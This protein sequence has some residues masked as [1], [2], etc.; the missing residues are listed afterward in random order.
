MSTKL[1]ML[2]I[3]LAFPAITFA[4]TAEAPKPLTAQEKADIY[5]L[6]A[7]IHECDAVMASVRDQFTAQ[8]NEAV[9]TLRKKKQT[10]QEALKTKIEAF[11]ADGYQLDRKLTWQTV[12]K[13]AAP[14]PK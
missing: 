4:Q 10:A 6:L 1:F 7:E 12:P 3:L 5:E 11:K 9:A 2:L 13:P 14:P 8:L